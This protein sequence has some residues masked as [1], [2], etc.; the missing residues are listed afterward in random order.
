MMRLSLASSTILVS[1]L[2][3]AACGGADKG[4]QELPPPAVTVTRVAPHALSGALTASGRLT[5]REEVAIA[6]DLNGY[7]IARV[8]VEEGAVVRRGQILATLDDSLLRSQVD[9]LQAA[10][11]QQQ[12]AA[13]QARQQAGRVSGLDGQGVL[14]EEAIQ[15]RRIAVKS[16]EA[17]VAVTR[18]QLRDLL[19][20]RDHMAI[21]APMDGVVLERAARP[22]ETSSSGTILFRL[23]RD[24]LIELYAEMPEADV[25]Q[26]AIGDPADVLLASGQTVRGTVRLLGERVDNQTGLVIARIAL[27]R[28]D[29]LRQGGFARARFLRTA[30]VQAVPEAAVQFDADGAS[31]KTVDR[32]NRVHRV[33]V[34]TGR[35]ANGWVE[36]VEGPPTG[37]IIAV[38]GSAF[39]LDN[40]VVRIVT[41][42]AMSRGAAA[43]SST[44]PASTGAGR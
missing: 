32:N 42:A 28:N 7:R 24:S 5:P 9:Q 17:A 21:R 43:S 14:S 10:L 44:A 16:S 34:R 18:A 15:N 23:A 13:E 36:L 11:S 1:V 4:R 31:V 30:T 19:V 40:D 39:T 12:I 35:R 20:R 6:S 2:L 38:K 3:L 22:G 25:A 33:H 27:P 41:D 26:I 37:T 8:L 29:A